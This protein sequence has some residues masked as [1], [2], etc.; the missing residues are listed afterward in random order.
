MYPGGSLINVIP[1]QDYVLHT[2]RRPQIQTSDL[3]P[4]SMH[5]LKLRNFESLG[6]IVCNPAIFLRHFPSILKDFFQGRH[7]QEAGLKL[8][9]E[10]HQPGDY[11]AENDDSDISMEVIEV[12]QGSDSSSPAHS[13]NSFQ[14]DRNP[15]LLDEDPPQSGSENYDNDLRSS[16]PLS[17]RHMC[18]NELFSLE[19]PRLV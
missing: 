1:D 12:T 10:L 9:T 17:P 11:A 18:L 19:L 16:V 13:N 8:A 4:P 3:I 2:D 14:F 7:S 15:K 5:L 6:E